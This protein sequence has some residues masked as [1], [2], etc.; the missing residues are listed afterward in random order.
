MVTRYVSVDETI[1]RL[2]LANCVAVR[3]RTANTVCNAK[4]GFIQIITNQI[5]ARRWVL[6]QDL[7]SHKK[8]TSNIQSFGLRNQSRQVNEVGS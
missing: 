4:N 1:S 2:K 5:I 8:A 7:C 6:A 3:E